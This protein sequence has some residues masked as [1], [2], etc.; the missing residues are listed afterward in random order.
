MDIH[1]NNVNNML[2]KKSENYIE[3]SFQYNPYLIN[4]V[5]ALPGRT[6]SPK[7]RS[8]FIPFF[9]SDDSVALLKSKGFYVDPLLEKSLQEEKQRAKDIE[10]LA[11]KEDTEFKTSLPLYNFQR[12][13]A[14]FLDN[15]GSGLLGDEPGAGKTL[16]TIAVVEKNEAQKVLVFCP[17]VLK[18]QWEHEINKFVPDKKAIVIEGSK[19]ERSTLWNKDAVYYIVNYELLLRDF[20][21]M[22]RY[23]WD[24]I[25][26]D[27]CTKISSPQAKQSKT[28]K[29]LKAKH[30]IAMSG[31]P[32]ANTAQNIWNILDFCNPGCLG[33]YWNFINRYCVKNYFG[34][35]DSYQNL[36]ELSQKIKRYM[37]RRLKKDIL[38][39]LPDRIEI[40]I[41]FVLS[42]EE[43]DLQKKI[44]Q[45]ILFEINKLDISKIDNPMTL[46]HTIVKFGRLRQ[47]ADSLEL[48]GEN[49]TSTKLEVLKELLEEFKN[50]DH[51][52][53]IFSEFAEMC[54]ILNRELQEYNPLMIIGETSDRERIVNDFNNKKEHQILIMSSAGMYGLNLQVSDTIIN[55]D[56]PFSLSKLEQRIGRAHR[57][58]QKNSVSVYSLIGKGTADMAIKRII[59]TKKNLSDNLLGDVPINMKDIRDMLEEPY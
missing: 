3:I 9:G 52:I 57:I 30:K 41:P 28:I 16:Q 43:K 37:I 56:L 23:E 32:I 46:Q 14:S 36:D 26:A 12:V 38:P 48:L 35:I 51:K 29:K 6:Y 49:K 27:E 39:E 1:I 24:Y 2:L 7:T 19:K 34:A 58:N 18:H 21:E 55:Y 33:S 54:K 10:L 40:D 50:T 44:K 45:E 11:N 5:K 42:K 59:H 22:S 8:W 17:S 53:I 13:G 20:E 4:I 31:T 47:L 25:L 15:I